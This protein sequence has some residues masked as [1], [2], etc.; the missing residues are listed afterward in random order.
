[1]RVRALRLRA[2][3]VEVL[4][5]EEIFAVRVDASQAAAALGAG[6][7]T[8]DPDEVIEDRRFFSIDELRSLDMLVSPGWLDRFLAAVAQ[9]SAPVGD[10]LHTHEDE[11]E[12]VGGDDEEM[13]DLVV[14]E[15]AR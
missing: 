15:P 13:E 3:G 11:E 2:P 9:P 1:M 12:A 14:A 4:Q 6:S 5:S 10:D 7:I 8:G